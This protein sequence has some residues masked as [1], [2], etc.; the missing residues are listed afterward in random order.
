MK[1]ILII[2]SRYSGLKNDPN[3]I[4]QAIIDSGLQSSVVYWEDLLL[5]IVAGQVSILCEGQNMI[6]QKPDLVIA[7]GWYRNG[8]KSIY[9]D[10]AFSVALFLEHHNIKF[11]NSEMLNQRS[12][13][14][15][16]AMVQLALNGVPVPDSYFCLRNNISA[17]QLDRPFIAKAAGASRGENNYLI[18]TEDDLGPIINSEIGFVFQKF[19]V[20]DHDLRIICFNGRPYLALKRSR[21]PGADTHL[22][23]TSKGGSAQWLE[24][25]DLDPSL[26]TLSQKICKITKRE[27]AGIDFIPDMSSEVGYSCLE[28]NAIPQLT[29]GTD[30]QK[31]LKALALALDDIKETD[32]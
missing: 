12:S 5:S 25:S 15:L 4:H 24:L 23:N 31:K 22:N 13:T 18:K 14:K 16:S 26:L 32:L 10:L 19:L 11:W 27:M 2:G 30:Y 7:L 29:S 8:R 21:Q 1:R 3:K 6:N 20:N 17:G 9:R 28:V